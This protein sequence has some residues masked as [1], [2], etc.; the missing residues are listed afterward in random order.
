MAQDPLPL[1]PQEYLEFI[2]FYNQSGTLLDTGVNLSGLSA[3][4]GENTAEF[5][6]NST[7]IR[8]D[9]KD[10]GY[11]KTESGGVTTYSYQLV[12][13]VRLKNELSGFVENQVYDT[14]AP[15]SLTYRV[16]KIEGGVTTLSEQRTISFKI[17]AVH[18]YLAE[19]S[20]IKVDS[21]GKPLEGAEF[22]L[23]HNTTACPIC[24]GDG[25]NHVDVPN[26]T[27]IS[28][29]N[30]TVTFERIPSGH[31]YTLQEIKAPPGYISDAKQY[32]V[33][34]A[35]D[36]LTIDG[37]WNGTVVNKTGSEFPSTGG[38][39]ILPYILT[40]LFLVIAPVVCEYIRRRK[41][42]RRSGV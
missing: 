3:E 29:A 26:Y 19:L 1:A 35:Y 5:A 36:V 17:P 31:I 21:Y 24:R 6:S 18:G 4:N 10:S 40:G 38:T 32:K 15:T 9:L 37:E 11:T 25:N 8:W 42:E 20:F 16:F 22:K 41:R 14:N 27:V 28:A 2:G 34:V 39:G 23:S 13:R 7:T 30:G 12:Y 33:V